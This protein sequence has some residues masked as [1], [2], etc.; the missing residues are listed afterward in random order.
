MGRRRPSRSCLRLGRNRGRFPYTPGLEDWSV[1]NQ[2][3]EIFGEDA[4]GLSPLEAVI[5]WTQQ[6]AIKQGGGRPHEPTTTNRLWGLSIK[7]HP[8]LQGPGI[9]RGHPG[10]RNHGQSTPKNTWGL[11][12]CDHNGST[13]DLTKNAP[14]TSAP[15]P[16]RG[17]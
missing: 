1:L 11:D 7:H 10:R 15:R 9:W 2:C 4:K 3:L 13:I 5:W 16:G 8:R 17:P 14:Q 12:Y 6:A